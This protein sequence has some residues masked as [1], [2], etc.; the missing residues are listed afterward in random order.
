MTKA[1]QIAVMI[2]AAFL[3]VAG[4]ALIRSGLRGRALPL[5]GVGC[6]VLAGYG[7]VL[8]LLPVDFSRLLGTYVAFFA[9]ASVVLGR[10][11]FREEVATSTWIGLAIV[12][13]GSAVMLCGRR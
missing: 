7:I 2:A 1:H 13:V 5:I 4:D 12:W 8:N 10:V 11:L 6:A 9:L 3:E